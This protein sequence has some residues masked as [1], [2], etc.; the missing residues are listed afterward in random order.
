MPSLEVTE[1]LDLVKTRRLWEKKAF[2]QYIFQVH[3]PVEAFVA[4][5]AHAPKYRI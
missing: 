5:G 2:V 4:Y 3:E 1:S